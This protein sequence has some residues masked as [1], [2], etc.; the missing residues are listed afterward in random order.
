MKKIIIIET[1]KIIENLRFRFI[2]YMLCQIYDQSEI[3]YEEKK[4]NGNHEI[5]WLAE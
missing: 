5:M 3:Q 1:R 4:E 2:K